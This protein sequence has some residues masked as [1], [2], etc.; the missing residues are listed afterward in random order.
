MNRVLR[1][2]AAVVA[3]TGCALP[4]TAQAAELGFYVGGFYAE[5]SKDAQIGFFDEY[6]LGVYDVNGFTPVQGS[7]AVE[8]KDSGYGFLGG[9][10]LL[11]NLAFEGEYME[12]GAVEYRAT[13]DGSFVSGPVTG[14]ATFNVNVDSGT[15]GMA[16]S[17][18]GIL[19]VSYRWEAYARL[20]VLIATNEFDSFLSDGA[21]TGRDSFNESSI[22]YLAGIGA[23][24]LFAE[25]YT[26]RFEFRRVFD[27]G[28]DETG[29]GDVDL[30]S[31]GFTVGF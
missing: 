29:E 10:R 27:A 23:G 28:A 17:A 1:A 13:S 9:Y 5:S 12:L 26:A 14:P 6:A 20:G 18:L 16:L 7:L 11:R 21:R 22:D 19:P 15:S 31:F 8:D 2:F 3:A 24:F 30:I 4:A 25:I